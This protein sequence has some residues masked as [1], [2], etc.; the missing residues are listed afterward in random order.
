MQYRNRSRIIAELLLAVRDD[1]MG[2][3]VKIHPLFRRCNISYTRLKILIAT[4]EGAGLVKEIGAGGSK[5]YMISQEGARYL[6]VWSRFDGFAQSY[7][8]KL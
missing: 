8:L 1:N 4:L 7:G 6:E 5:L 2:N 3:G